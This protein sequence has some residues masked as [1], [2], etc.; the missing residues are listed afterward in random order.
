[1][2]NPLSEKSVYD[3]TIK[4]L[5]L[6]G[7]IAW[8]VLIMFPFINILLWSLI[9]SITFLPLHKKLTKKF[10]GKPKLASFI[11]IISIMVLIIIP[12]GLLIDSL[13]SEVKLL[14]VKYD[15]GTLTVPPPSENVK[16]W[17]LIGEDLYDFWLNATQNIK[18]VIIKY[19]DH[20]LDFG[21]T[22]VMGILSATGGFVQIILSLLISLVILVNEGSGESIRKFF[23][24]VGGAGGDE[25]A[26]L[27][28]KTIR[29]VLKGVIGESFVIASLF[30]IV[31]F[32]AGVPYA[33]I[34]TL[35]VFVLS[36][37]QM[38]L[39]LV[40]VPV[41]V[42]IFAVK[43]LTPAIISAIALFL[44]SF[45]NNFL[46]PYMLGKGAPVPMPVIYIGVIGGF[47]LNGFIGLFTGPIMMSIGYTL[48][49]EWINTDKVKS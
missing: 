6:L 39:I 8:C 27:T 25:F 19:K 45:S 32:I 43:D 3:I 10:G 12:A 1:M 47:M 11:I 29:S 26:D 24:A 34:W 22:L 21:S 28:I 13:V 17:P 33:G 2:Y 15:N 36:V 9:F 40:W 4:L 46:T 41:A 30:G 7:I 5:I 42:Y 48:F 35:L 14:Q 16:G 44:V 18:Q 49:V 23:R 31:F 20:L 38:P 37:F